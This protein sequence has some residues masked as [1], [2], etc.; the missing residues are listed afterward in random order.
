M[1]K[2]VVKEE[3]FLFLSILEIMLV[4]SFLSEGFWRAFGIAKLILFGKGLCI[5][6]RSVGDTIMI[7]QK[8]G[9]IA[10][11]GLFNLHCSFFC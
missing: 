7:D 1:E 9:P 2:G 10:P 5:V 11:L 6:V 3:A 8:G 4:D